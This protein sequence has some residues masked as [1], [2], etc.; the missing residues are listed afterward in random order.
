MALLRNLVFIFVLL[1]SV[2][3]VM[4]VLPFIKVK[5]EMRGIK[6]EIW[7]LSRRCK[8]IERKFIKDIK[9]RE[10]IINNP[11]KISFF[12]K[13]IDQINKTDFCN[14]LTAEQLSQL[15]VSNP[16]LLQTRVEEYLCYRQTVRI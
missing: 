8:R 4:Y 15:F 2:I 5:L 13:A 9:F 3:L 1:L 10:L 14:G 7:I 11:Y 6:T 12:F 16:E